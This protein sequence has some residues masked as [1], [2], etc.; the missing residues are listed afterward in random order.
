MTKYL[1]DVNRQGDKTII[2]K[3]SSPEEALE[4]LEEKWGEKNIIIPPHLPESKEHLE[5]VELNQ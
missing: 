2:V 1:A 4:K 5:A 3:A